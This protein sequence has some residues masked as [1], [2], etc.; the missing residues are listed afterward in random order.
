MRVAFRHS[1]C[2]DPLVCVS[3]GARGAFPLVQG[4][5]EG[6]TPEPNMASQQR[7]PPGAG[8]G[9]AANPTNNPPTASQQTQL[10]NKKR[11]AGGDREGGGAEPSAME[12]FHSTFQAA[13]TQELEA[14]TRDLQAAAGSVA[15][16]KYGAGAGGGG[17]GGGIANNKSAKTATSKSEK[18]VKDGAAPAPDAAAA[19]VDDADATRTM[20]GE[21]VAR[22]SFVLATYRA[23]VAAEDAV[24]L[25]ALAARVANVARAYE[26]EHEAE[27]ELFDGRGILSSR[28]ALSL[29]ALSS[30]LSHYKSR[31][32]ATPLPFPAPPGPPFPAVHTT[33]LTMTS[34]S[35]C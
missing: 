9:R 26:L 7:A 25:P 28:G 27:D 10:L 1:S 24:V 19:D 3:N 14:L 2:A 23:H 31:R 35:F 20:V 22:W 8:G 30:F 4:T 17:G 32:P 6:P 13:L 21:L 15:D 29:C 33:A 34:T 12:R 16:P 18:N 11:N 5:E